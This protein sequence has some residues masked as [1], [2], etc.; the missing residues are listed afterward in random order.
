MAAMTMVTDEDSV[1]GHMDASPSQNDFAS[2]TAG[3]PVTTS[4]TG[5]P[6]PVADQQAAVQSPAAL[7]APPPAPQ[8]AHPDS[9][10]PLEALMSLPASQRWTPLSL[11]CRMWHTERKRTLSGDRRPRLADLPDFI[12]VQPLYRVHQDETRVLQ[13][14]ELAKGGLDGIHEKHCAACRQCT[15]TKQMLLCQGC[16]Y[17]YHR[18]CCKP[19]VRVVDSRDFYCADCQSQGLPDKKPEAP[20]APVT[21]HVPRKNKARSQAPAAAVPPAKKAI[22]DPGEPSHASVK[23][24]QVQVPAQPQQH[25]YVKTITAPMVEGAAAAAAAAGAVMADT[26]TRENYRVLF[27]FLSRL[28]DN[29]FITKHEQGLMKNLII[30]RDPQAVVMLS[31]IDIVESGGDLNDAVDSLRRILLVQ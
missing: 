26:F 15:R 8:P 10:L 4:M 30:A 5:E 28:G 31:I 20:V 29:G 6:S 27:N 14:L 12:K 22:T 21:V 17:V 9:M 24:Q 11:R 3:A 23:Q 7:P 18:E 16:T 19:P 25:Q 1:A 2:P 13:V